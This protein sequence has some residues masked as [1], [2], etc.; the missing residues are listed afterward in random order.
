MYLS[1]P[2]ISI[3]CLCT[4][5]WELL[6]FLLSGKWGAVGVWMDESS[7]ISDEVAFHDD[8]RWNV[9]PLGAKV[10]TWFLE[11]HTSVW[12]IHSL[13]LIYSSDSQTF[14]V[15]KTLW[16]IEISF[17]TYH[18]KTVKDPKWLWARQHYMISSVWLTK[19]S[20]HF[21]CKSTRNYYAT[22]SVIVWVLKFTM[23]SYIPVCIF[24]M[25][26]WNDF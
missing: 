4:D 24:K 8:G 3:W 12:M 25:K 2:W 22:A 13:T 17:L 23:M 20:H 11:M 18:L 14:C 10:T 1:I 9:V 19:M 21:I 26:S 16:N 7:T 5:G 15:L 6:V